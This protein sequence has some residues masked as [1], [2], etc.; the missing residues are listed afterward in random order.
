MEDYGCGI[1][2]IAM[3]LLVVALLLLG[4]LGMPPL[5]PPPAY[6]FL[7]FAFVL[8]FVFIYLSHAS[9]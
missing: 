6:I 1:N 7:I 8:V 3:M 2:S 5:Q 9:K 4:P